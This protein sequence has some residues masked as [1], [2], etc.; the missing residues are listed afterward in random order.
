MGCGASTDYSAEAYAKFKNDA[1][2][3]CCFVVFIV[4]TR[5]CLVCDEL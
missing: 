5:R 1:E 3:R 4:E 2:A